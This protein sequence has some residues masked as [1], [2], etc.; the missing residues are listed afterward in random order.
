MKPS[1]VIATPLPAPSLRRPRRLRR[2]TVRWATE[3]P[4]RSATAVTVRE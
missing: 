1:T 2:E 4:S 3:G